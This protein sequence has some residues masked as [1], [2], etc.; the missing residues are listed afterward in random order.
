VSAFVNIAFV[1]S[2][3][4]TRKMSLV[5]Q[6]VKTLKKNKQLDNTIIVFAS[7]NGC[8]S[9]IGV[10]GKYKKNGFLLSFCSLI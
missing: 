7:D 5:R 6:I 1:A 9:Y 8:A 2:V 4:V 3:D 10:I